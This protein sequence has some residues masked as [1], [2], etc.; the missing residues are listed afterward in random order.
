MDGA[1]A[2]VHRL[3]RSVDR[4]RLL[5]LAGCVEDAD[6]IPKTNDPG[7]PAYDE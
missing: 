5:H 6:P 4:N 3:A 2:N 1:E 7:P